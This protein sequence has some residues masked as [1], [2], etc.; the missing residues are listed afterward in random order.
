[1]SKMNR[2]RRK[3]G[4]VHRDL[5]T[6]RS[7]SCTCREGHCFHAKALRR[8]KGKIEPRNRNL[9]AA[10]EQKHGDAAGDGQASQYCQWTFVF[11]SMALTGR[12]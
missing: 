12:C 8:K 7:S 5:P 10:A 1:M 11:S 4:N 9:T 6:I 2:E 3:K